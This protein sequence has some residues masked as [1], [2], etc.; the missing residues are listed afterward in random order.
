MVPESSRSML[1]KTL[2]SASGVS[3]IMRVGR[4]DARQRQ[5]VVIVSLHVERGGAKRADDRS[6]KVSK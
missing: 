3:G 4:K 2:R 6:I 1:L 5:G